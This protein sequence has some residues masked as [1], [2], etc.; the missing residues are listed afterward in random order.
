MRNN[1]KGAL[2]ITLR[3]FLQI[4]NPPEMFDVVV[5]GSGPAGTAVVERLRKRCPTLRVCVL[6]RGPV[7][8]TTHV[9][10]LLPERDIGFAR[11]MGDDSRRAR[12]ITAFEEHPWLGDFAAVSGETPGKTGGMLL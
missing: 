5:V 3:E 1:V 8:T 7:L 12:F 10:N 2:T 6:E 9:N 11:G 4:E